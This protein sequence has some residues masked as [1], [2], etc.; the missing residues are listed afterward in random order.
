MER[1]ELEEKGRVFKAVKG[2]YRSATL[3]PDGRQ[4]AHERG[5][6]MEEAGTVT[7]WEVGMNTCDT[8]EDSFGIAGV[9]GK[10]TAGT[11]VHRCGVR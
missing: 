1:L 4:S 7:R 11:R 5:C 8:G 2:D 9:E 10:A 3:I 6:A